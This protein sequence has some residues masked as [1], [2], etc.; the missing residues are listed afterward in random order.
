M[1]IL[2]TKEYEKWIARLKDKEAI[3][4]IVNRIRRMELGNFGVCR[5]PQRTEELCRK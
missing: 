2:K 1:I 3:L 4:R 5:Y